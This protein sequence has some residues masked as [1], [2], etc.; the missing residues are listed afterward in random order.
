MAMRLDFGKAPEYSP[1]D[2]TE[3]AAACRIARQRVEAEI[4]LLENAVDQRW[5][6]QLPDG[7]QPSKRAEK[8]G[9]VESMAARLLKALGITDPDCAIDGLP[10]EKLLR[11]FLMGLP[12]DAT[13]DTLRLALDDVA[14]LAKWAG[15]VAMLARCAKAA[16]ASLGEAAWEEKA[17]IYG[18]PHRDDD[19]VK[20]AL[21]G[22]MPGNAGDKACEH[23][24]RN[25]G[26][27]YKSWTGEPP[28]ANWD[29]AADKPRGF[30]LFAL[31]AGRPFGLVPKQAR[32]LRNLISRKRKTILS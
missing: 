26:K 17:A 22:V 2:I 14:S 13:E 3:I 25:L 28:T 6:P 27:V 32:A 12:D 15:S 21:R 29:R 19:A 23:W 8:L 16:R 31:L 9:D 30:T 10:D 4:H 5:Q 24:L 18:P 20:G 11:A 1:Q 7:W